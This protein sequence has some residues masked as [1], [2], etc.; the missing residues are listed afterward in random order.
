[1]LGNFLFTPKYYAAAGYHCVFAQFLLEE[2]PMPITVDQLLSTILEAYVEVDA[3]LFITQMNAKAETLMRRDRSVAIGMKLDEVIP[4]ATRS[5]HWQAF[6]DLVASNRAE[7]IS[8]FYPAQYRWHDVTVIPLAPPGTGLLMRDV[9]DRQW[10]I[11]REAESVYLRNVF[12]DIPVAIMVARG[13]HLQIEFMNAFSRQ[14]IGSRNVVGLP[15]RD[16]FPDIEQRE[17]FDIIESV[18]A[19]GVPFSAT[20]V[21]VRF[22]R[23][24]DGELEEGFFDVSYHAVRD[25]DGAISGIL[26]L[27][28][29][30][31]D[32]HRTRSDS[33]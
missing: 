12:E 8:I 14:L 31:T 7:T 17:L 21:F 10:L 23:N 11:R 26:S 27:S 25:F 18:F 29:E 9:T 16:A 28:I 32:R 6:M 24:N 1:L 2:K 19:T 22:D 20:D 5:Q 30:V 33:R 4:D 13:K 15:L 3:N